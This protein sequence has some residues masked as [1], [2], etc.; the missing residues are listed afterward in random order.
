MNEVL[1]GKTVESVYRI[2]TQNGDVRWIS[3][4]RLPVWDKQENRAVKFYGVAQDITDRK[5]TEEAL[6]E[7]EERYRIISELMSD[8]AYMYRI[9]P[10]GSITAL[11]MTESFERV[12]GYNME[13]VND[14]GKNYTLYHPDYVETALKDVEKTTHGAPT[15][16]EYLIYNREGALH[17]LNIIRRP[18]WNKDHTQVTGFYGVAKDITDRKHAEAHKIRRAMEHER[19]NLIS[20]FVRAVSHDFRTSLTTIETNR[21]L[22]ERTMPDSD[23][24]KL[25]QRLSSIHDAVQRLTEQMQNLTMVSSLIDLNAHPCDLNELLHT[26]ITKQTPFAESK[27]I[28]IELQEDES[29]LEILADSEEMEQAIKHLVTNAIAYTPEGGE[30]RIHT[31]QQD[32][33][34]NIEIS[35]TG[36]GIDAEHI[37]HIFDFFYRADKA[38]STHSGGVG[39]GLSIVKLI[40]E[41]HN[42]SVSVESALGKGSVFTLTLP[43]H[44]NQ[45]LPG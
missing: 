3:L 31:Y 4:R 45:P 2:I 42:G 43:V 28:H 12:T 35:D 11:W 30:I 15:D 21:Y 38:R 16:N 17:W 7:S 18:I 6:R 27:G 24:A 14:H 34:V 44:I 40:A 23:E 19:L 1:A 39:L 32:S 33:T 9:E 5:M 20:S 25:H 37:P 36:E 41:A 8:Y 22:I 10:D 26:V 29:T 13:D